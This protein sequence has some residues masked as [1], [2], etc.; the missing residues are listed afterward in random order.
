MDHS[1][2]HQ[3]LRNATIPGLLIDRV[4]KTPQKVAF[5][6]K[7]L[8]IY[9]ELTWSGFFHRIARC[10][11]GLYEL[12]LRQG[13]HLALMADPCEE[14]VT[15]ELAAQALGSVTYGIH[16]ACS[17]QELHDLME[18]GRACVFVAQ[19]QEY[20]DRI[21]PLLSDLPALRK[22]V[23][24]DTRGLLNYD[25]PSM[26]SFENLLQRGQESLTVR[27]GA[28]EELAASV[29]PSDGAIIA[30]TSGTTG[31]P[32]GVWITH[33]KHLAATYGFVESYPILAER[34]H[35]T[36]AYL[37]LSTLVGKV[38][39][40]TLPLLADVVPHFCEDIDDLGTTMFEVAPTVLFV[41]PRYLRKLASNVFVSMESSS[42]LKRA[43]YAMALDRGRRDLKR[44]WE[45][46]ETPWSR[47]RG[48][49]WKHAAFRPILN[50]LGLDRTEILISTGAPL[51][52][53]I[54]AFW[55]I[56]GLN[57]SEFYG[58]TESSGAPIC[59]QRPFFPRPHDTGKPSQEWTIR[60]SE[61]GEV[62]VRG[63][64]LFEGYWNPP[65]R[66]R[67]A[68]SQDGWFH[69]GDGG[70]WDPDG[71][72]KLL[73]RPLDVIVQ[74]EEKIGPTHIENLLRANP[75]ISEA[76]VLGHGYPYLSSLIE[77]DF[78]AVS[79]W[80][81]RHRIPFTGF[82]GMIAHPEI[83]RFI[84]SEIEKINTTLS[85]HERIRAFTVLPIELTP[86]EDG[87]AVT[88]T[89]KTKRDVMCKKFKDLIESMYP[90]S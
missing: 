30:Y 90:E 63:K 64:D 33:G 17:R 53:E 10:T 13:E 80:A 54:T 50:K 87:A 60:L 22:I 11:L 9:R 6:S 77:I 7:K 45:D 69:T 86:A 12:G 29:K 49:I 83:I 66:N 35:R 89:R 57:V 68:F 31:A 44:V 72:L 27:P 23:L 62:L 55:H 81:N 2:R 78:E 70:E 58:L 85:P 67:R 28:F 16:P 42:P 19:N 36:V 1:K 40:V 73:D 21:L 14:V 26:V 39:A 41:M 24:I 4:R 43:I 5:R 84:G 75:Y 74:N 71:N 82:A 59:A 8:G 15:C 88:P 47:F 37:P 34:E 79:D 76:V 46:R 32:K 38:A 18:H 48:S 65:E 56:C 20:L 61:D 52:P 25:H 3:E 51:P